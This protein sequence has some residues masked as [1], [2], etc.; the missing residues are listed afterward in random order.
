M[1]RPG[2]VTMQLIGPDWAHSRQCFRHPPTDAE[3]DAWVH[4]PAALEALPCP[5]L[6]RQ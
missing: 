1:P 2:S 5:C 4:N 3:L 6:V